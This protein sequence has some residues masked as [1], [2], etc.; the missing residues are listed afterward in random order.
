MDITS[1]ILLNKLKVLRRR[2]LKWRL[3][4]EDL[5]DHQFLIYIA[6][7]RFKENQNLDLSL[8]LSMEDIYNREDLHHQLSRKFNLWI[9]SN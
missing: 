6:G 1:N 3:K 8:Q 9:D 7:I 5:S 4:I 2:A